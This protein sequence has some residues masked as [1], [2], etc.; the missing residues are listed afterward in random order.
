M[1]RTRRTH[2]DRGQVGIVMRYLNERRGEVVTKDD[3][4]RALYPNP[5]REPTLPGDVARK[6]LT[7]LRCEHGVTIE[8]VSGWR[9]PK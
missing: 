3:L 7:I 4:I 1:K 6:M 2:R 8:T 5:D 9:L